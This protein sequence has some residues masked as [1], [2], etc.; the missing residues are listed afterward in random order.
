MD[1]AAKEEEMIDLHKACEGLKRLQDGLAITDF[2]QTEATATA[3]MA[4]LDQALDAAAGEAPPA[5]LPALIGFLTAWVQDF[6]KNGEAAWPELAPVEL[7]RHL[8]EQN[9]LTQR[10][11]AADFG[12]QSVVSKVLKGERSINARQAVRLGKRFALSAAAFLEDAQGVAADHRQPQPAPQAPAPLHT[13]LLHGSAQFES[14]LPEW[15]VQ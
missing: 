8:M 5:G 14:S 11:L 12:G 1:G 9:G 3:M 13:R 10:D 4:L 2:S 6:E 15:P 7:L